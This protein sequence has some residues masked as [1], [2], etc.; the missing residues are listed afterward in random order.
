MIPSTR[1]LSLAFLVLAMG[2]AV[3][4][5]GKYKGLEFLEACSKRDPELESCLARTA[6]TLVENFRR[7]EWIEASGYLLFLLLC[8]F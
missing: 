4:A 5:V 7:G 8:W 1:I 6:N 2:C 3:Q